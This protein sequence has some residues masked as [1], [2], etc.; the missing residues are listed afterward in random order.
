M[1]TYLLTI[2]FTC[3][4][5]FAMAQTSWSD[6]F[7]NY[8]AGDL[9]AEVSEDWITWP[10]S[11][12]PGT[13]ADAVVVNDLA[14]GGLNSLLINGFTGDASGTDIVLPFGQVFDSGVFT[15]SMDVLVPNG[16][17]AYFNLQ[18]TGTPGEVWAFQCVFDPNGGFAA[19]NG[20]G[21]VVFTNAYTQGEW[22]NLLVEINFESNLWRLFQDG[23]C[24]GSFEQNTPE[25]MSVG[26]LNLFPNN[27]NAEY[28]VDNVSF[29]H[30]PDGEGVEINLDVA[31]TTLAI[32][33]EANSVT[34]GAGY[35]GIT[36]TDVNPQFVVQ[37]SGTEDIT[38]LDLDIVLSGGATYTSSWTG[39]IAPGDLGIVTVDPITLEAGNQTANIFLKNVNGQ[40]DDDNSC[41]NVATTSFNGFTMNPDRGY[42]VE[43][44]TGT[45]CPNCPRG[46]IYMNYM[47]K[48]YDKKF[49]GIAIHIGNQAA[50]YPDPMQY[51]DWA[52]GISDYSNLFP[53]VVANRKRVDPLLGPQD[54]EDD[55][56]A[57]VS[58]NPLVTLNHGASWNET[59]RELTVDVQTNFNLPLSGDI[60]LIVGLTEDGVTGDGQFWAQTNNFSGATVPVGG[61]EDLPNPIPG[62]MMTYNHVARHLFTDFAGEEGIFEGEDITIGSEIVRRF[63]VVV[64]DDFNT[65]NMHIVSAFVGNG[66]AVDNAYTTTIDE[67]VAAGLLTSTSDPVFDSGISVYPNPFRNNAN[68]RINLETPQNVRMEVT[69]AMGRLV[70][71]RNYGIVSGDQVFT[72][73]GEN[74]TPGVY[75]MKLFNGDKFTTKRIMLSE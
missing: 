21:N 31:S 19:D 43:E 54:M 17:D 27:A 52:I 42:W 36:G 62:S 59:T 34:F 65:K 9:I 46:D 49:V 66:G 1:R 68:I 56:A 30:D 20:N 74:M 22:V 14:A 23:V 47:A 2:L 60:R 3:A 48:K 72:F 38:S 15:L 71:S 61:Y 10:G 24:L 18:A 7:E 67:S 75:Y 8:T 58:Q 25:R 64:P 35:T 12:G 4:V 45:W 41:N 50:N 11:S 6:D 69:D 16:R 39:M 73:N 28:Y 33:P 70:A 53:T 57:F 5:G 44:L 32:N 40:G 55:F 29:E 63:T 51:D 37:N 26:S 13:T